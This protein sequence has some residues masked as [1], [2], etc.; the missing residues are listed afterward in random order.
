LDECLA[1]G[2]V[3]D[4]VHA[5]QVSDVAGIDAGLAVLDPAELGRRPFQ[6]MGNFAVRQPGFF[7]QAA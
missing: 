6:T 7:A 4:A 1:G 5:Q 2:L 3:A